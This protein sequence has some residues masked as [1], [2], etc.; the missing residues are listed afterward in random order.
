MGNRAALLGLGHHLGL[1]TRSDGTTVPPVPQQVPPVVL[2]RA[3]W[4]H[5][6]VRRE[7]SAHG[8]QREQ[9]RQVPTRCSSQR[10][11]KV[12]KQFS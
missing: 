1:I 7:P 4:L 5:Q 9:S 6:L 2:H 8:C 11:G 10:R 12:E 3:G